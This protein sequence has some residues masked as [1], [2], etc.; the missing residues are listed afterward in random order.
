MLEFLLSINT[1]VVIDCENARK[2][3]LKIDE[4][5]L[6]ENQSEYS[7]NLVA[8]PANISFPVFLQVCRKGNLNQIKGL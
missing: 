5:T 7:I 4:S 6:F 2:V 1:S 3:L 8:F